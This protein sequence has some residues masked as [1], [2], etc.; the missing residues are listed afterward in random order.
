MIT[1][2]RGN[3]RFSYRVT[4]VAIRDGKVLLQKPVEGGFCFLPGGRAELQ[5]SAGET[6]RREMQEELHV[7]VTV[8][9]LLWVV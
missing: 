9:R 5:E 8:G 2:D 3:L 1:F 6:L 7:D 4:G